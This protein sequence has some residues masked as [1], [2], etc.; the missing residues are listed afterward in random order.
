MSRFGGRFGIRLKNRFG[1]R[2]VSRFG[3]RFV[4]RLKN[5]FGRRLMSRFGGR[6]E[7][8]SHNDKHRRICDGYD[9]SRGVN[10]VVCVDIVDR[11]CVVCRTV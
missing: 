8:Y 7:E 10:S 2:F 3:G 1:S 9:D 11:D 6:V 5:R 4:S